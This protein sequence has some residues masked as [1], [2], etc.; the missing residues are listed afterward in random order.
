MTLRIRLVLAACVCAAML[1]AAPTSASAR[2]LPGVVADDLAPPLAGWSTRGAPRLRP[3]HLRDGAGLSLS[4][5]GSLDFRLE[6]RSALSIRLGSG[7]IVLAR[8]GNYDELSIRGPGVQA[9]VVPVGWPGPA[10]WWHLE[11]AVG[12]HSTLSFEGQE[13]DSQLEFGEAIELS[14][15]RGT[16]R[17]T[18]LVAT[19][20]DDGR[21][22]LLHRLAELHA[23]TPLGRFPVGIGADDGL[24]R[25][26]GGWTDGFWAGSL[27]RAYDLTRAPLF[28]GWAAAA[29]TDHLGSEGQRIH[30]Q[31]FRYLESSAAAYDRTCRTSAA[32]AGTRCRRLR[33]SALTAANVL[34]DLAKENPGTGTIPTVGTEK[35][36]RACAS[37]AEAETIV[38]S[39]MNLGLLHW[40]YARTHR[41]AYR[42][43]ALT[44]AL[45]VAR[46]LVRADGSTA[47]GVRTNRSDGRVLG[48]EHRQGQ[49]ADSTW[50][51]G[52]AWAI[53]GYA[54]TGAALRRL[55][56]IA[57]SER[58]AEYVRTHL[59]ASDVPLYDYDAPTG[60]PEDTSAAV[61]TAAG[62]FRL[63][64]ACKR[65]EGTC[66]HVGTWTALARRML[67]AS[68]AHVTRVDPIGM[69]G[70]QVYS[71]GGSATWDDRGEYVFGLDYALEAIRRSLG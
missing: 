9:T 24:L 68:L 45:A 20:S 11:I 65:F 39:V 21:A 41:A 53:Y 48:V 38:D 64:A 43:T 22:R 16:A 8:K 58:L 36:C 25:F 62:L 19:R 5:S 37:P 6:P 7:P 13:L 51:R 57:L 34:V 54:Q 1:A 14:A 63:A 29:T 42:D 23:R 60:S 49:S 15:T 26:A 47:Q 69:L 35:Q 59:P 71:L 40:A 27:W 18:G 67:D 2:T 30:D 3:A 66:A 10:G 28:G 44:H 52:Q 46:L 17:L 31:G 32:R 4:G 12:P 61:I 50:A 70:D 33:A 55:D 56:L